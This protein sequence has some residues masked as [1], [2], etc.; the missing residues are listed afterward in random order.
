VVTAIAVE[1]VVKLFA[2]I[3]V[4]IFVVWGVADGAADI[5]NRIDAS[6]IAQFNVDNS[7]WIGLTFLSAAAFICL[8]RMFQVLV[9][10]NEDENNLSIASW[11]FPLYLAAMSL[12]VVPI[13]VVGLELLPEGSNPDL[14]VLTI[15]L[16][17]GADG[18]A[19]LAFL[20]GFSSATS[21]VIV[22][23]LALATMVSN[24]MVMPLYLRAQ[25]I[26]A[27]VSGDVRAVVLV[28][29]RLSIVAVL[30]LGLYLLRGFW[31]HCGAVVHRPHLVCRGCTGVACVDRW[32]VLARRHAHRCGPWVD[33]GVQH[34]D[35]YAAVAYTVCGYERVF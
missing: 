27:T 24:N 32:A 31:R 33:R 25:N 15:P 6:E 22:A 12:F 23:A 20:G 1:A 11:A 29:R 17:Q 35:V 5:K 8:P 9:V 2:L 13:A 7:R 30:L 10:E 21:M 16:T 26:G 14:F 19:L 3:A 4:G 28:S 18:L 34:L